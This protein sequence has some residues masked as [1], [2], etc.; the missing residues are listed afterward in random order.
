MQ[1]VAVRRQHLLVWCDPPQWPFLWR[2]LLPLLA[3]ALLVLIA[4]G[5]FAHDTIQAEVQREIRTQLNAADLGWTRLSVSG[6]SVMLSGEAPAAAAAQRAVALALGATCATWIGRH[7]CAVSVEEHFTSPDRG[8]A[9]AAPGA[10]AAACERP[11]ATV[12]A[13]AQIEFASGSAAMD[14]RSAPLL[15]R[16]AREVRS[17]PGILRIEGHTDIVGRTA[18]NRSLSEARA[19]AVR[20]ALMARGIPARRLRAQGVGASRPVADN[21]TEDG[22]ARNRRIE[23]HLQ[24]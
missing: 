15:D 1:S 4:L 21:G 11:L 24:G 6:Q 14:A 16:L 17:C 12:L 22:R 23:V 5:P 7:V 20:D 2:G 10:A 18:F 8:A 9:D 13:G 3:L 19:V